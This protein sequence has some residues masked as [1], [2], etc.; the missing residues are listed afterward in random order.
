MKTY[1]I[2]LWEAV[3]ENSLGIPSNK[4]E[5]NIKMDPRRYIVRIGDS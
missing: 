4:L 1:I 2:L 5:N 3:G